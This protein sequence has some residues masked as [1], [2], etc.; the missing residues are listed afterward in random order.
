MPPERVLFLEG[1]PENAPPAPLLPAG[2]ECLFWRPSLTRIWPPGLGAAIFAI[3]WLLH[4]LQVFENRGFAEFL[5][6]HDGD[7]VHRSVVTPRYFRFPFMRARDLQVGDVWTRESER[8]R[9]L[10]SFAL[11]SILMADRDRERPYWYVVEESNLVSI[12]VAERACFRRA[13]SGAR[14]SR[15]GL[16]LL[17]A[18][19]MGEQFHG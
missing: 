12:R 16:R 8:G 5:I 6:R 1:R 4:M 19:R 11:L 2:Y 17:G 13:G 15:L 18:Y 14:T 3:W 7:W 9:G 10:A